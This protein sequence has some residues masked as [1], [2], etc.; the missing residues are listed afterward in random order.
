[1]VCIQCCALD[2]YQYMTTILDKLKVQYKDQ[3]STAKIEISII[4]IFL[5]LPCTVYVSVKAKSSHNGPERYGLT[6]FPSSK[7][8]VCKSTYF[9]GHLLTIRVNPGGK[10]IVEDEEVVTLTELTMA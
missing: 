8:H 3:V 9:S 1:M 5:Y 7:L 6:Y 2:T 10:Q 4:A